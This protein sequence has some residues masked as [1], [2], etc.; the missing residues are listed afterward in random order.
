M[1]DRLDFS[2]VYPNFLMYILCILQVSSGLGQ[3]HRNLIETKQ[4]PPNIIHFWP[5]LYLNIIHTP[6]NPRKKKKKEEEDSKQTDD[7]DENTFF[8]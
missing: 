3:I 1:A 6:R 7:D 2:Q 4:P 5:L 8:A